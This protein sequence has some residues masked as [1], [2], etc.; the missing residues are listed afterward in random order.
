MSDSATE[1][2]EMKR[3]RRWI[4]LFYVLMAIVPLNF[5]LFKI[6]PGFASVWVKCDGPCLPLITRG[7]CWPEAAETGLEAWECKTVDGRFWVSLTKFGSHEVIHEHSSHS[8][9]QIER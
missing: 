8:D 2:R 3:K 6:M 4:K 7:F 9:F 5:V 1:T